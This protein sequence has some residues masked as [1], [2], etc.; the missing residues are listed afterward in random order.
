MLYLIYKK[1][2][3]F[4]FEKEIVIVLKMLIGN[5]LL[6]GKFIILCFLIIKLLLFFLE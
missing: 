6:K 2:N 4:F 1:V 3:Y 5:I